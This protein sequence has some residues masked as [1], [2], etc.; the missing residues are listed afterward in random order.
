LRC[1]AAQQAARWV[2]EGCCSSDDEQLVLH[3]LK[4][5]Q[6]SAASSL[7]HTGSCLHGRKML[8][9]LLPVALAA[10]AVLAL[11]SAAAAQTAAVG[12]A[13]AASAATAAAA[14]KVAAAGVAVTGM[15]SPWAAAVAGRTA[16]TRVTQQV[17]P[18]TKRHCKGKSPTWQAAAAAP[19][20]P[21]WWQRSSG[22]GTGFRSPLSCQTREPFCCGANPRAL[23]QPYLHTWSARVGAAALRAAAKPW[24][25]CRSRESSLACGP[26]FLLKPPHLPPPLNNHLAPVQRHSEHQQRRPGPRPHRPVLPL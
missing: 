12:A 2:G 23:T 11:A 22:R 10:A 9:L 7:P 5:R 26:F 21:A 25:T 1:P 14:A 20:H 3:W 4:C 19:R 24:A 13:G 16:P 15:A 8:G 18:R 6:P 17:T